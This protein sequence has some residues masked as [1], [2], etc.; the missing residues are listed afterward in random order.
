[1]TNVVYTRFIYDS[2]RLLANSRERGSLR[3][4]IIARRRPAYFPMPTDLRIVKSYEFTRFFPPDR[5]LRPC[6][7]FIVRWAPTL[8]L[9]FVLVHRRRYR[10]V[11]SRIDDISYLRILTDGI[12]NSRY[13]SF[14]LATYMIQN[15]IESVHFEISG[16]LG[17]LLFLLPRTG[18]G[19]FPRRERRVD[20]AER[21]SGTKESNEKLP[22]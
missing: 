16:D 21:S 5:Y 9:T 1:M 19:K 4:K 14:F 13:S 18:R 8:T 17:F 2:R 20:A 6:P 11:P 7:D 15:I 12:I 10:S 22:G 3:G